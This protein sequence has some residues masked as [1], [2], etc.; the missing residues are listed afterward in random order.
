VADNAGIAFSKLAISSSN[1]DSLVQ[2]AGYLKGIGNVKDE[3]IAN[4]A[5]ISTSKLMGSLLSIANH[6][7]G[8]LATANTI[9]DSDWDG[10]AL[11]L[12]NGGTGAT[13]AFDARKNLGIPNGT[14]SGQVLS[15]NGSSWSPT[16][17]IVGYLRPSTW[18][19]DIFHPYDDTG[20]IKG[21]GYNFTPVF[22]TLT[23]DNLEE[24][25]GQ[26]Y[27]GSADSDGV[28]SLAMYSDY[29]IFLTTAKYNSSTPTRYSKI[30][31][32]AGRYVDTTPP[33]LRRYNGDLRLLSGRIQ[34][35]GEDS[36]TITSNALTVS[37]NAFLFQT[38]NTHSGFHFKNLY[39]SSGTLNVLTLE[40]PVTTLS[41]QHQF[42]Q[43]K[44]SQDKVFGA[45]HGYS[46][47][48]TSGI[49]LAS[50]GADY[51]EYLPK[52]DKTETM[53][54]A[55]IVGVVGGKITKK[56]TRAQKVMVI[57][58]QPIVL[59]NWKG[60]DTQGH[61]AVAFIGQVPVRVQG[62][63]KLGDY[64]IPSGHHDGTGI[65]VSPSQLTV[66]HLPYIVGQA[67]ESSDRPDTKLI[68]V[69]I[70]ISLDSASHVMLSMKAEM[71]ILKA[72]NDSLKGQLKEYYANL[73][74]ENDVFRAQ[75]DDLLLKLA[76]RSEGPD[77]FSTRPLR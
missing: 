40:I 64:I 35:L 30:I 9:N 77:S 46:N 50:Y 54:P 44:G 59:G 13:N 6:G 26:M 5:A 73:K 18:N 38:Y 2:Q 29:S 37:S 17:D 57:S 19:A 34:L 24:S 27:I 3:H 15:W 68:T 58:S 63:V 1:I 55:D 32:E 11:S 10:T 42:I 28:Q 36:I 70:T 49:T 69:A 65:A 75:M 8:K 16:S 67:W 52:M 47:G 20:F 33:Y 76:S 66:N 39:T 14:T 53:R 12:L 72:E 60:P 45:I 43:F 62:P 48:G 7:L 61:E 74:K 31:L 41:Q 56:T 25:S 21:I 71:D 23:G 51:A 4:D 22:P